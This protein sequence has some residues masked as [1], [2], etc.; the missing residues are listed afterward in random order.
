MRLLSSRT[1][2]PPLYEC[3][4]RGWCKDSGQPADITVSFLL[5]HELLH[6]LATEFREIPWTTLTPSQAG[7]AERRSAW[8][9]DMGLSA[10][11][12]EYAVL[13]AQLAARRR[14]AVHSIARSECG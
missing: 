10:D 4:L 3:E 1:P 12:S 9:A 13:G 7:L 11:P 14:L 8:V 2:L 5:P 6:S